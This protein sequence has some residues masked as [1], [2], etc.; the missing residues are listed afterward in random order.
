[1]NK[2]PIIRKPVFQVCI[3]YSEAL[4]DVTDLIEEGSKFNSDLLVTFLRDNQIFSSYDQIDLGNQA[5]T[6]SDERSFYSYLF[7]DRKNPDP[8][9]SMLIVC[10]V[11]ETKEK[12][13]G[14]FASSQDVLTVRPVSIIVGEKFEGILLYQMDCCPVFSY[15]AALQIDGLHTVNRDPLQLDPALAIQNNQFRILEKLPREAN[16]RDLAFIAGLLDHALN[17]HHK[18]NHGHFAPQNVLGL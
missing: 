3:K 6:R 12:G 16:E 10:E 7:A 8:R 5:I 2:A 1:M 17:P 14:L 15:F 4:Q 13:K 9:N 11:F 18:C